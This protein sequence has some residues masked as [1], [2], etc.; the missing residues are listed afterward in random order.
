MS[1]HNSKKG[2]ILIS[3]D[4]EKEFERIKSELIPNRVVGFIED[5]FK[6]EHSKAVIA[7]SYI[8]ESATKY[9]VLGAK[10][11]NNVSQ[12]SL[13]KVL[14]E[15]PKNIEFIIISPTKSNLLATIRSR[16]PIVKGKKEYTLQNIELSIQR[17]SYEDI[18]AFL[19]ANV[20]VS[21]VKQKLW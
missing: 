7:E 16:M 13:L 19:K 2:Y 3:S 11:F 18:F 20:R 10:S 6:I 5:E 15:P 14:E 12:N 8:S 9:I 1:A 4:I 17:L 21:K